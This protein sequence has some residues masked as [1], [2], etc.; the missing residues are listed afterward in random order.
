MRET[1]RLNGITSIYSGYLYSGY[2]LWHDTSKSLQLDSAVIWHEK[3]ESLMGKHSFTLI[4]LL[5]VVAIIGIL[6]AI[7][8]P[9]FLHA[10]TKA[11]V[12]RVIAD[13]K[14]MDQQLRLYWLDYNRPPVSDYVLGKNSIIRLSTPMAYMSSVPVD[15]YRAGKAEYKQSYG[16]FYNYWYNEED[17]SGRY[18]TGG[19]E[20]NTEGWE[21]YLLSL[22]PGFNPD[23]MWVTYNPSNGII[24]RGTIR[25]FTPRRLRDWTDLL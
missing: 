8:V 9:N 15:P 2:L 4:E 10:R 24:S 18:K 14:T 7:A 17:P 22:G 5:I 11:Q 1:I 12:T 6:A 20:W 21:I 25:F 3:W 23:F 16:D 13:M 19:T